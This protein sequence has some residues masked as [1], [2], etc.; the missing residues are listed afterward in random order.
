MIS[1]RR[2]RGVLWI[3]CVAAA[4]PGVVGCRFQGRAKLPSRE[5]SI[6]AIENEPWGQPN[7]VLAEVNGRRITRGE[8]YLRV[9]RR[10]G[11]L[12]TLAG[13]LKEELFFQEAQRL[14]LKVDSA[15]IDQRVEEHFAD[16]K[17]RVGGL[18][19]LEEEYRRQGLELEAVRED[20]RREIST[21]LLF[22]EVTKALRVVDEDVILNYYKS[23]YSLQRYVARQLAYSF[24]TEPG[25]PPGTL[26]RRKLQARGKALRAI[27]RLRNGADFETLARSESDDPMTSERGGWL[28]EVT[29]ETPMVPAVKEAILALKPGEVSEPIENPGLGYHVIQVTEIKESESFVDCREKIA[30]ELKTMEPE[31]RE[32]ASTLR[33]LERRGSVRMF[34]APFVS[35]RPAPKLNVPPEARVDGASGDADA[36]AGAGGDAGAG[37]DASAGAASEARADGAKAGADE[38]VSEEGSG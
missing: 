27:D 14:G 22:G 9:L 38:S 15:K 33:E 34:E 13:I 31:M 2:C 37:A 26:E 20:L 23:T 29:E 4:L 21:Q 24:R 19:K 35:A 11:T 36:S 10:Y 25:E 7:A 32:I 18:E 17:R 16:Q 12:V 30:E 5:E 1:L 3:A 6:K 28:P 8:F